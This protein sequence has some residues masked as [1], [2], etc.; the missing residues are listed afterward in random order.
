MSHFVFVY[1]TLQRGQPLHY[2][3]TKPPNGHATFIGEGRT[4]DK[5]PLVVATEFKA[6]FILDKPGVGHV[7]DIR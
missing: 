3:M 5:W 6:P 4:V 7:S 1:G 2:L